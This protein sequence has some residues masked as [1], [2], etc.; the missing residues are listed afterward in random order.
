VKELSPAE[1]ARLDRILNVLEPID[2]DAAASALK[3]AKAVLDA[4]GVTFFLRQGTCLGAVRSGA[5][6]P[7][8]DDVDI[9]SVIGLHGFTEDRVEPLVEAFRDIGFLT[10]IERKD[11]YLYVPLVKPGVRIDWCIYWIMDAAVFMYPASRIPI[12]FL[13]ELHEIE[14]LGDTYRVPNP[15]EEYLVTKYG[16]DWRTPKR[17][18]DYEGDILQIIPEAV[19]PGRA[20]RLKQLLARNLLR[21]RAARI[22]VLDGE[23]RS[24]PGAEVSVAG[25]GVTRA[26]DSGVVRLYLPRKDHYAMLVRYGDHEGIL[27]VEWVEPGARYRYRPGEEH[28]LPGDSRT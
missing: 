12:R 28:L 25:L 17:A 3:E 11:Q 7:W 27:Y 21:W 16:P 13:E 26:D 20:G 9:G 14:F 18:G 24:V 1:E 10:R 22:T 23:G 8:D 4:A 2:V 19:A 6:I 5:L 15:P